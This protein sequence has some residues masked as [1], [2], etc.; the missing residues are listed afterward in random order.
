VE[1]T[2][3]LVYILTIKNS[4]ALADYAFYEKRV[5]ENGTPFRPLSSTHSLTRV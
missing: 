2:R 1:F 5:E 3:P 4:D